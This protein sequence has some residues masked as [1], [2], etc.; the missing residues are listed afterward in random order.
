MPA[1]QTNDLQPYVPL[2]PPKVPILSGSIYYEP[3]PEPKRKRK[4]PDLA[5]PKEEEIERFFKGIDS[6]RDRAILAI[7]AQP[8]ERV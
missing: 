1:T 8:P 5:T 3:D 7:S 2:Q 6:P 4:K